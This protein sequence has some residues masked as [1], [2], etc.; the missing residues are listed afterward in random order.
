MFF[1]SFQVDLCLCGAAVVGTVVYYQYRKWLSEEEERKRSKAIKK[2]RFVKPKWLIRKEQEKDWQ[3]PAKTPE[4]IVA[5]NH[6][7]PP[8]VWNTVILFPDLNQ[9]SPKGSTR[10]LIDYIKNARTSVYL[11]MYVCSNYLLSN[12]VRSKYDDGLIVRCVSEYDTWTAHNNKGIKDLAKR[13]IEV[14]LNRNGFLMHNKFLIIDEEAV[15][16]GSLNWTRQV[17]KTVEVYLGYC[18]VLF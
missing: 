6:R 7:K 16:T 1:T 8:D 4:Q 5:L 11:C 18:A 3:T 13:G 10:V 12:A 14:R 9:S 17:W 15:I 2:R